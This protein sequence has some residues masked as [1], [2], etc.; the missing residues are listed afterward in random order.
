MGK[1]FSGLAT[2]WASFAVGVL[3]DPTSVLYPKVNEYLNQR[4]RWRV[5]KM[6]E[7]WTEKIILQSPEDENE[8]AYYREL[9]WLLNWLYE[10]LRT[11]ADVDTLRKTTVLEKVFATFLSPAL[12]NGFGGKIF[13]LVVDG[14]RLEREAS[15]QGKIR[16]LVLRI[17]GR[18][19]AVGGAT[20][21]ITRTGILGWLAEVKSM[22]WV[23]KEGVTFLTGL[24]KVIIERSDKERVGEWSGGTI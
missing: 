16:P 9:I 7:Y 12:G 5:S 19:V 14:P 1:K 8:G 13:E 6:A 17:V 3:V 15:L 24:E 22:S 11:E 23:G 18:V 21:L 2:T 20:T 4:P 10:G